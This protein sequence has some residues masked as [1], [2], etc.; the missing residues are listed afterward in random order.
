MVNKLGE[1]LYKQ[2]LE[3]FVIDKHSK[4][5]AVVVQRK[6]RFNELA[7]GPESLFF[8]LTR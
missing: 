7:K 6:E 1:P 2:M 3:D 5:I 4:E 8:F